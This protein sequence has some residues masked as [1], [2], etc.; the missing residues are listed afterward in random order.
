[1][2]K[3]YSNQ[4]IDNKHRGSRESLGNMHLVNGII[5]KIL[6]WKQSVKLRLG[7][8]WWYS[9]V[10]MVVHP[11]GGLIDMYVGMFLV[12]DVLP[13]ET[14]GA[15]LPLV[16]LLAFAVIPMKV[17]V[18]VVTKYLNKFH[19]AGSVGRI[20]RML[21]DLSLTAL[22]L[23]LAAIIVL[24]F[25]EE[26]IQ[27]RVKFENDLVFWILV[28]GVAVQY[29]LAIAR[30]ALNGLMK[31]RVLILGRL[32]KPVA[33]LVIALLFLKSL[34]LAGYV[35]ANVAGSVALLLFFI[36]S[37]KGTFKEAHSTESYLGEIRNMTRYASGAGA[38]AI[39]C[40]LNQLIGPW[41]VR[42]FTSPNESG[43]YY[44]G[45]LLGGIP[46]TIAGA[47]KPFLFPLISAKFEERSSTR[48]YLYQFSC[49]VG[50]V[51]LLSAA[52]LFVAGDFILSLR[53][54]WSVF[55]AHS[56]ILWRF[57]LLITLEG[58]IFAYVAHEKARSRFFYSKV[59]VPLHL[60]HMICFYSIMGWDFY[61]SHL[62]QALWQRISTI[63]GDPGLNFV[64]WWLLAFQLIL[65]IIA[66]TH[67]CS[68][69]HKDT[70]PPN[71]P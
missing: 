71:T 53:S 32:V 65:A 69:R 35:L 30:A 49:V 24:F 70:T 4:T 47:A 40:A 33:R 36:L 59:M 60:V 1:M 67:L 50:A 66:T 57:A 58:L 48:T 42:N 28:A 7:H 25:L 5:S 38:F 39:V 21:R 64:V 16:K 61:E 43:A 27:K 29:S 18:D 20:K 41:V 22:V 46:L 45:F 55:S 15:I 2:P 13:P 23:S 37:I 56:S 11:V 14:L 34:Q 62:P 63:I 44:I 52:V 8:L 68:T 10:R 12:P 6:S 9:A 54:S 17:L 3:V 51:G 26:P 19:I 31:F